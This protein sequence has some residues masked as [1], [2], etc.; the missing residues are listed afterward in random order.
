MVSYGVATEQEVDIETLEKRL[1]EERDDADAVYL[2]GFVF[3]G[4]GFVAPRPATRP[5]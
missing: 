2:G 5:A 1:A 3:G 4:W